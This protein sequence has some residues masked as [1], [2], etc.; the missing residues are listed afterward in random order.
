[1]SYSLCA[2]VR[3]FAPSCARLYSGGISARPVPPPRGGITTPHLFLQA[4][5]RQAETKISFGTWEELFQADKA[6]L[7][8]AGV[9]VRDRRYILWCV[10]KFRL[11][12]DPKGFAH[13]LKPKKKIRGR[14]PAV[15]NGKRIRSRRKR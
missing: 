12:E 13:E 1:M 6:S 3:A 15:Q 11:G 9:E 10:Q 5:G 8:E 14:G 4:I 7:K 2:R